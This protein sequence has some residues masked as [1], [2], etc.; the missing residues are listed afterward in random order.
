MS[1]TNLSLL[2]EFFWWHQRRI[3]NDWIKDEN[4]V[5]SMPFWNNIFI[6]SRI[7]ENIFYC[8][9]YVGRM[10]SIYTLDNSVRMWNESIGTY[11]K[12]VNTF[13]MLNV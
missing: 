6:A 1:T 7:S 12:D 9:L 10:P 2:E 8:K 13:H 3:T 5:D 11:P 4:E